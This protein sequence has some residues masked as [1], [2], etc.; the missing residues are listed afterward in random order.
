M[1][2]R[3]GMESGEMKKMKIEGMNNC[4]EEQDDC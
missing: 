1:E 3:L 2:Q 4:R